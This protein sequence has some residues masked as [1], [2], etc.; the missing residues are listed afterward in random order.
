MHLINADRLIEVVCLGPLRLH[1][2]YRRQALH[3]AC[4]TG[5]QFRAK[6]KGIGLE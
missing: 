5:P 2:T 4:G 1:G 6:G 3:D